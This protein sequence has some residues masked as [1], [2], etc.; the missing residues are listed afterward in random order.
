[1]FP[2]LILYCIG[3]PL[4]HSTH[5]GPSSVLGEGSS[6]DDN[7]VI[8]NSVIGRNCVIGKNVMIEGSFVWNNVI[9]QDN[10]RIHF[11]VI[12]DGCIIKAG[13]TIQP[14]SILS[15]NVSDILCKIFQL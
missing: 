7:C 5:I 14:G 1:M 8:L 6:V 12:C 9:I 10:A 2:S 4:P 11:A 15:F 13:A 3:L